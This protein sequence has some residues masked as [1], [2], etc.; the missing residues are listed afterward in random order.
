MRKSHELKAEWYSQR[1]KCWISVAKDCIALK[2]GP[3]ITLKIATARLSC[4]ANLYIG[5]TGGGGGVEAGHF[6]MGKEN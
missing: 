3:Q 2:N 1:I 4:C 5:V 6:V